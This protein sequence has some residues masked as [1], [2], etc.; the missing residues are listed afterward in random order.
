MERQR[1]PA[2]VFGTIATSLRS[3][4][5]N[6]FLPDDPYNEGNKV[7]GYCTFLGGKLTGS[8]GDNGFDARART[9][10]RVFGR[11]DCAATPGAPPSCGSDLKTPYDPETTFH[12]GDMFGF[13]DSLLYKPPRHEPG[14]LPRAAVLRLVRAAHP[15]PAAALAAADPRLSLR[16]GAVVPARRPLRPGQ[17]LR[18]GVVPAD[19]DRDARDQL[20]RRVRDVR[21]RLVDGQRHARDPRV[22]RPH[23]RAALHRTDGQGLF[24]LTQQTC[25]GTWAASI[26]PSLPE[27]TVIM[28]LSDNGWHLPNSK[29]EFTENGYR[30]RLI[31]FDP[32][33]L[34]SVPGWDAD[35]Q[36]IPPAQESRSPGALHRHPR[37]RPRVR[38]QLAARDPALPDGADGTRCDG[39]DL[40]NH[41]LTAPG[42]PAAPESLRHALCG[43]DTQ[44]ST[45][46][47]NLRYLLTR[48]GSVGR[49]TLLSAPACSSDAQC[50][51]G[52]VCLG[53]HCTGERRAH[54]CQR[55]RLP[56]RRGV[57]RRQVPRR[58]VLHRRRGL[59]G[60]LP[61]RQLGLCREGHPLVPERPQRALH[62]AERLSAV[63]GRRGLPP[64]LRAPAVEVLLRPRGRIEGGG[65]ERP[66]PR[67]R[68]AR[69]A[70]R[71]PR[72]DQ[73]G[74]RDVES[75]RPV[76][77]EDAPGELLR[78]RLVVRAGEHRDHLRRW[79][80]RRPDLQSVTRRPAR[81]TLRR[82]RGPASVR[83]P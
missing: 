34:P 4:D 68:R 28:Q 81:R 2:T 25:T 71:H 57:F 7:G 6:P 23:Q 13:L 60:P 15:A 20:R 69:P 42:G 62:D 3:L 37:H 59:R 1:R 66:V 11:T 54:L 12:L 44:R 53:G 47:D 74:Q 38:A 58:P 41:L 78:R 9:G 30:T 65:A 63:P 36:V 26:T 46:P 45:G 80:S 29:H 32:T 48:Q 56:G 43:H 16:Q 50:P 24:G 76:R 73:A 75:Q 18:R 72:L 51:G 64:A 77:C 40:R 19:R 27:H 52:R 10:E 35:Q 55:R 79:L 17:P 49:C 21:Q 70:Q 83:P 8:I 22:S 5:N 33:A 31:V 39:K 82:P 67:S 14:G 61:G